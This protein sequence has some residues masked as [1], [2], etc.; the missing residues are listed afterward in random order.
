GPGKILRLSRDPAG[1]ARA[2]MQLAALRAAWNA[3]APVPEPGDRVT[4]EGR[5]GLV[6]ERIEGPDLLSLIGRRPWTLFWVANTLGR[7]HAK[8]HEVMAPPSLPSLR[9]SLRMRIEMG[10][11]LPA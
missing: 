2:D 4:V 8:L 11:A 7:V 9:E 1:G 3:G 5:P 6:M 10:T